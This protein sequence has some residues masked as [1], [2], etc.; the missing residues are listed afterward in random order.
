MTIIS[1]IK[2]PEDLASHEVDFG[3]AVAESLWKKT[4]FMQNWLNS[5]IPIGYL[6][7]HH[8]GQTLANGD[9]I[10][11]PN[12]E[13][14]ALCDGSQIIDANSPLNGQFTPDLRKIFLKGATVIGLTGGQTT[15]NISH[16]HGNNLVV[17][18]DDNGNT[19]A[20][21]GGDYNAGTPHTHAVSSAWSS[22]E[23]NIPPFKELQIY[24]RKK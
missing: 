3:T 14:W 15:I 16:S 23:P 10:T 24:M 21:S 5:S 17:E 20:R 7:F 11:P 1:N 4:G 9:P 13:T 22:A 2:R 6:L 12:P 8:G 18:N 19:N